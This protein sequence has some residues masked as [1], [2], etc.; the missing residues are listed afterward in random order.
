MDRT[1][2]QQRRARMARRGLAAIALALCAVVLGLT[3]PAGAQDGDLEDPLDDV[4][5]CMVD[6]S[7]GTPTIDPVTGELVC[8]A[9][10]DDGFGAGLDD[11]FDS[12]GFD[13]YDYDVPDYSSS[14]DGDGLAIAL[15]IGGALFFGA[16]GLAR[17]LA[18][19]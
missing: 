11:G 9:P 19:S 4:L 2:G 13:A 16:I 8:A 15:K 18:R 10:G 14:D 5:E 3:Q 1:P 7:L 6:P 12:S 17:R